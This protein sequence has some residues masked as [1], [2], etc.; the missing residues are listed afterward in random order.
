MVEVEEG[1]LPPSLEYVEF[2][3]SLVRVAKW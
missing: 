1:R 2:L 3:E